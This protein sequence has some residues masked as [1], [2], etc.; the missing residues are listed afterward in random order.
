MDLSFRK[1]VIE[2]SFILVYF[3][4]LQQNLSP[5]GASHQG[6]HTCVFMD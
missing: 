4:E 3:F 6:K 2:V 1:E 5:A